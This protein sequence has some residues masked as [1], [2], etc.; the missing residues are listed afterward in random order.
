MKEFGATSIA[1]RAWIAST[2]RPGPQV[3]MGAEKVLLLTSPCPDVPM[4]QIDLPGV[5]PVGLPCPDTARSG[6]RARA[7][8]K[9]EHLMKTRYP[10][11]LARPGPTPLILAII[12][13]ALMSACGGGGGASGGGVGGRSRAARYSGDHYL[14]A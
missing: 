8:P 6:A 13:S 11:S 9:E 3:C 10:E 2:D 12:A 1:R 4:R 5:K 14:G 7:P